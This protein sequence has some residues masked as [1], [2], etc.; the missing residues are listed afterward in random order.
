MRLTT[1]LL[2]L[3][4]I[5]SIQF[6][7]VHTES[8]TGTWSNPT[9]T[10]SSSNICC[11]PDSI[12]ISLNSLTEGG[13]ATYNIGA[14]YMNR[15]CLTLFGSVTSATIDLSYMGPD[16]YYGTK[17]SQMALKAGYFYYQVGSSGKLRISSDDSCDFTMNTKTGKIFDFYIFI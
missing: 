10:S 2:P 1:I 13:V 3:V 7:S 6:S 4:L 16:Y 15:Q 12:T 8:I 11:I 5:F 14:M 17:Y 9:T